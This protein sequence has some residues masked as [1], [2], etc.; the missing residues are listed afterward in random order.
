MKTLKIFTIRSNAIA[1]MLG[2]TLMLFSQ[3]AF[4]QDP[5]NN[6]RKEE[7]RMQQGVLK[8]AKVT[9]RILT[10][11]EEIGP[12][13]VRLNVLNP[14]EKP[15]RI[16]IL[17]YQNQPVFQESFRGR[18]YNK[19]LN[20]NN[21][22]PGRYSLHVDGRKNSET[23]RFEVASKE[24]RELTAS[25]LERSGNTDVIATIYKSS[26]TNVMLQMVNNTGK[27]V[28]YIFRDN[29]QQVIHRGFAK[30]EKFAKTFDMSDIT[31][32]KY[33]VEVKYMTDKAASRGFDMNTIYERS[34]TWVDRRGHPIKPGQ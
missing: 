23:R 33:T 24:K 20:F 22:I 2:F 18:E 29:N 34:F 4:A 7:K 17:N 14:T 26:P 21:T 12:M 32:G 16:S 31:D 5:K 19:V 15:V 25:E 11:V 13:R 9:A 27:P 6:N 28:E 30:D 8:E 1:I 10:T 3:S